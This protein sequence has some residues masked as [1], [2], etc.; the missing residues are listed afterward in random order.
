MVIVAMVFPRIKPSRRDPLINRWSRDFLRIVNMTIHL[1]GERPPSTISST[2]FVANHVSWLDIV[3]L[4]AIRRVRFV[5]KSEVRSWPVV[6]W[7]ASRTGTFFIKRGNGQQLCRL[8]GV[9][10]NALTKGHCVALFPE[11]TTTDGTIL[12]PFN[13]GLLEAALTAEAIV[14]PVAIRYTDAEDVQTTAPAFIGNQT[15]VESL[16]RVL[17]QP[18]LQ[19]HLLFAP[20]LFPQGMSRRE[21]TA[22][23]QAA[24]ASLLAIPSPGSSLESEAPVEISDVSNVS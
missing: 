16:A 20:P 7:L 19:A 1:H 14:W 8:T 11:G 22:H 5:A 6:G 23:A 2:L 24:I 21:L 10:R 15:L 9:I 4:N 13:G 3:V 18:T 17:I 12:Q